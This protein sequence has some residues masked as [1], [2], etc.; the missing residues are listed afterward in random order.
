MVLKI[1][2]DGGVLFS[3]DDCV[4]G[5]FVYLVLCV[6]YLLDGLLLLVSCVFGK[7][8]DLGIYESMIINL[9]YFC[10]YLI[11]QFELFNDGYE[12]IIE[13][14]LF[15]ME[16]FFFYVFD[17]V[18]DLDMNVVSFVELVC[19][20]FYVDLFKIDDDCFNGFK[21]SVL[22]EVC[23]LSLFDV[24]CVDYLLQCLCYYIGM[25]YEDVQ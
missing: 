11:E 15:D 7:F 12:V 3:V 13:V 6:S 24:L 4:F 20:F 22:G 14:G 2:L 21:F 18:D 16:I 10:D 17:G 23:F 25:L 8:I 5:V 1:F 19:Y 9:V